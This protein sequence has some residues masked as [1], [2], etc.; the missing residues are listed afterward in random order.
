MTVW[1]TIEEKFTKTKVMIDKKVLEKYRKL[2]NVGFECIKDGIP[3]HIKI[4]NLPRK[5]EDD[6]QT[7]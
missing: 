1:I 3:T 4:T 5:T 2:I 7:Y 6:T